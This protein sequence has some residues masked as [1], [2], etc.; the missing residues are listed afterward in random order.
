MLLTGQCHRIFWNYDVGLWLLH[1]AHTSVGFYRPC[2]AAG[3]FNSERIQ[4][5]WTDASPTKHFINNFSQS[6]SSEVQDHGRDLSSKFFF[7]GSGSTH[8]KVHVSHAAFCEIVKIVAWV[9]VCFAILE[10]TDNCVATLEPHD[11]CVC[12]DPTLNLQEGEGTRVV[13]MRTRVRRPQGNKKTSWIQ[14]VE[15]V[16]L[17]AGL[18]LSPLTWLEICLL[19]RCFLFLNPLTSQAN[20]RQLYRWVPFNPNTL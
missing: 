5:M 20:N 11:V 7:W 8:H 14:L 13:W 15:L 10:F 2:P 4:Q 3:T 19:Q 1:K 16:V 17:F 18:P 12:L 6:P 9:D